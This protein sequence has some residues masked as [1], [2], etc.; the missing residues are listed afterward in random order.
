MNWLIIF[1]AITTAIYILER[2]RENKLQNSESKK[3]PKQRQKL[4]L[5]N[6][7]AKLFKLIENGLSPMFITGEAGTGKSHLLKHFK[8]NTKKKVIIAAPT[9][10][11]ALAIGGQTLHSLF[12]LKPFYVKGEYSFVDPDVK[13]LFQHVDTLVIDEISM[14]RADLMDIIDSKLRLS[15]ENNKPFGGIQIVLFGD[16]YQLPPIINDV[17]EEKYLIEH[18]EGYYFFN[19]K[20]WDKL[21]IKIYELTNIYRQSAY[22]FKKILSAIRSG[23]ADIAII[24]ELNKRAS[25]P[26]P[27]KDVITLAATNK[28]VNHINN[29]RLS[30]IDAQQFVYTADV[31]GEAGQADNISEKVLNLKV[32]A[33]VMFTKNDKYKR[34]VNGTLATVAELGRQHIKVD[35]N[36]AKYI[37]PRVSWDKISYSYNQATRTLDKEI[38]SS[39]TQ[40]P[41]KLAWAVTVH[42]SQG[43]TFSRCV[44]D[45]KDGVFAHGQAYVALSRC[46]S[47]EGLF[48]ISPIR[49]EDI[50]VSKEVL[51]FMKKA[52]KL[53]ISNP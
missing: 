53:Q 8:E 45:L 36:G 2:S 9:G 49:P 31:K 15:R 37:V 51:S 1:L 20:V 21:P 23:R 10:I 52:R 19:A 40:F 25:V 22:K 17:K 6:Q 5:N 27:D 42:K 14:V 41:L 46:T 43:Q 39:I 30:K 29:L 3:R 12:K 4:A 44:V 35:V 13:L 50:Y 11:A 34:W 7:Q 47:L 48:L 32:G 38:I 18:Y 26:I 24:K 28:S 16:L 33:Q